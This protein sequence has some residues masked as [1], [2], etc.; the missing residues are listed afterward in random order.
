MD[1][2]ARHYGFEPNRAGFMRCPFHQGDHT[3]SLKVYA[4]DRGWHCFGCNSGGSVIDFVMR[5]YDINF[6]QA[7]LRLD[8]DFGLGLSQAPQRSRAEQSAILEARR[9]EAERRAVFER[10][11]HEKT[12][13]HRYWWEV[14]KYFAPTKEDAAGFIHPL[15]AEALRRQPY[16]EYWLEENL[17]KGVIT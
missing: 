6:R 15:Y 2:V 10:E 13:E 4:G 14:L 11:Y 17:G 5:L 1:E 16:L 7:V 3:A 9:R 12:V 8:L